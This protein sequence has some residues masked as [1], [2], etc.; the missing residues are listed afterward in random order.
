M[1]SLPDCNEDLI[2]TLDQ[3][4]AEECMTFLIPEFDTNDDAL[5]FVYKQSQD[6]LDVMCE[7]WDTR[8]ELWPKTRDRRLLKKWFDVEIHSEVIDIMRSPIEHDEY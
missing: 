2:P 6:I 4:R 7:S 1:A 5:E 8:E 3:A